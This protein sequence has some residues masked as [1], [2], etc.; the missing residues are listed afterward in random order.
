[1]VL[2][3]THLQ[4]RQA[5]LVPCCAQLART[6]YVFP[7]PSPPTPLQARQASFRKMRREVAHVVSL[8][9]KE[10]MKIRGHVA[11]IKVSHAP[12]L[13]WVVGAGECR[14][15]RRAWS[16]GMECWHIGL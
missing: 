15:W 5:S 9:F 8:K 14:G 6:S 12:Q 13:C 3:C 7:P 16:V 1:M 2:P 10:Y 11:S 4:A